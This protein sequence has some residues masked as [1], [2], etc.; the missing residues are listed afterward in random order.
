MRQVIIEIK[1]A[2]VVNTSSFGNM[3]TVDK[4]GKPIQNSNNFEELIHFN[5]ISNMLHVMMGSRPSSSRYNETYKKS[6]YLEDIVKNGLIRYD[7]AIK[8]SYENNGDI[9]N[10]YNNEFTQ[11]KKPFNNSNRSCLITASNGEKCGSYITWQKINERSLYNEQ[12]KDLIK[13]LNEFGSFINSKNVQ[14]DYYLLDL[15]IEIRKYPD[16]IEKIKSIKNI[17]PITNFITFKNHNSITDIGE[18]NSPN[19]AALSNINAV[20]PKVSVDATVI[21]FLND[22]DAQNLLH[23]KG[24]AS[25]LDGGYAKIKN[26]PQSIK[27]LTYIDDSMLEDVVEE[28][29]NSNFININTLPYT[30]KYEN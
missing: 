21:L 24:I 23:A 4:H 3:K 10:L 28:L 26:N 30:T 1:S 25:F 14:K 6:S 11:G 12:Y 2:K 27:D 13:L 16:W 9:K 15:L 20:T 29:K 22:E 7:N 19:R 17:S 8:I 5:H 18:N